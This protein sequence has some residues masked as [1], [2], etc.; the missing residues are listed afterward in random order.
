MKGYDIKKYPDRTSYAIMTNPFHPEITVRINTY[1]DLMH[2]KQICDAWKYSITGSIVP[3]ITIPCL[4]DA[5]ADDR[6]KE[7]SSFGL[8]LV[9][10]VLGTCDA[11][12]NI[13]HPHNPQAVKLG[14]ELLGKRV[15]IYDNSEFIRKALATL[16]KPK[17]YSLD[18]GFTDPSIF[19]N[20]VWLT[21][22]A[23]AYKWVNKTADNIG[24][25]GEVWSASKV[26]TYEDGK[27][28]LKQQ[29][30]TQDFG[31]KDVLI[32]DDLSIYGGTF[33][34][35]SKLLDQAN[36][37]KKYLAV[38]HMTIQQLGE[39]S[40]SRNSRPVTDFFDKVFTTNS[41]HSDYHTMVWNEKT[42]EDFIKPD[43]LEI[44]KL[45]D[46]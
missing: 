24:W 29:L 43:N 39:L 25:K 36:V 2:L 8:K 46:E 27:T 41:K 35:L 16:D 23:G 5:Q 17:N 32:I 33:K 9:L 26:R 1:E 19:E 37:G 10:E 30:P 28:K 7:G 12:F 44:I 45:F 31:G 15:H 18:G 22:D 34:G 40:P 13:F 4:L 11:V 20:L 42:G 21:P 14:L 38:S 3:T 6:F